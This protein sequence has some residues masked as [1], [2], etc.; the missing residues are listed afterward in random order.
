MDIKMEQEKMWQAVA[1]RDTGFDGQFVFGVRSTGIYCRPGC[2]AKTPKREQVVF[3]ATSAQAQAAGF[4]ACRRCLPDQLLRPTGQ[5][6]QAAQQEIEASEERLS[7]EELGRR[8]GASPYHLQRVFKAA[9]GLS[10]RQ[11]GEQLRQQ[12]LKDELRSGQDVTSAVYAAGYGSTGRAYANT[13]HSLGMPPGRYRNGGKGMRINY[14]MTNSPLGRLLVAAT[15]QGVCALTFGESDADLQAFLQSEFPAAELT[16]APE[17]LE[18]WLSAILAF[19]EGRSGSLEVPVNA[20][21]TAFQQRVW[22]ELR[23]IPY[24]QTRTYTQ[25]AQAIGSP[26]AV[27]AVAHACASNPASVVTPCHRVIRSDGSL[28]GYRWGL[29]RK[30]KLLR[31]E[32][33][34]R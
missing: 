30:E 4:R 11:Y 12:R 9:L 7:L 6:V 33:G 13:R 2:P 8:V 31:M 14:V 24:G 26:A 29:D 23:R 19:L 1:A 16:C 22:S 28:A 25:V 17:R 3:F 15:E 20:A 34:Q 5:L 21:G 10:P 18:P 32:R 27:R